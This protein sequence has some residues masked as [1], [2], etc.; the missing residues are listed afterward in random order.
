MIRLALAPLRLYLR[1]GGLVLDLT[2]GR[3][4]SDDFA[5]GYTPGMTTVVAIDEDPE[6]ALAIV[7]ALH[8]TYDLGYSQ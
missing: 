1:L 2:L 3:D 4:D 6:E 8:A 5:E 7:Q